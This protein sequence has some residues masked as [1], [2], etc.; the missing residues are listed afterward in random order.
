MGVCPKII[1][2]NAIIYQKYGVKDNK[3]IYLK[4]IYIWQN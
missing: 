3:Y 1:L 4:K 2:N